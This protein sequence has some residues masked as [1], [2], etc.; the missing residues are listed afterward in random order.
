MDI[1]WIVM[2]SNFCNLL[3]GA[4]W[5]EARFSGRYPYGMCLHAREQAFYR[6][7]YWLVDNADVNLE[8]IVGIDC[9]TEAA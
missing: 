9:L 1:D 2:F 7:R 3:E 4:L 6:Y 5:H 8:I